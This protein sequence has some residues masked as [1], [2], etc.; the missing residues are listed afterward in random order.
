DTSLASF[1][2]DRDLQN[3]IPIVKAAQ[4]IKANI[5]FWASPWTPPTWMKQ[6]P[7]SSGNVVSPF[8][9][10]RMKDDDVTM[11]AFAQ[12]LVK[13]VQAYAQQGIPIEAVS[14]PN[15]PN[16]TRNYPT[17]AWAPATYTKFV[18]QVLAPT[19]AEAGLTTK[20]MLG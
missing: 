14:P 10:G 15:K 11:S 1:S 16:Y 18:G 17:C 7:I 19:I 8:D 20:I 9:G 3:L 2:I 6:G 5:R 12:Y 13:F 4:A